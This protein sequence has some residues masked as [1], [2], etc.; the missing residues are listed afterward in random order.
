MLLTQCNWSPIHTVTLWVFY[1]EELVILE[2]MLLGRGRDP[3]LSPSS[4]WICLH[5]FHGAHQE[6]STAMSGDLGARSVA[7]WMDCSFSSSWETNEDEFGAVVWFDA[8]QELPSIA[9]LFIGMLYF[10]FV[11]LLAFRFFVPLI[12]KA[13]YMGTTMKKCRNV[14]LSEE[15]AT[16]SIF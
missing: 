14:D 2:N 9:C 5:S 12:E 1:N 10:I 6:A 11:E 8:K 15:L 7:I 13:I 3:S 16:S 4:W